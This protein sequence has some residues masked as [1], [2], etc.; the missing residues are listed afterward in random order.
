MFSC[1]FYQ[2]FQ[3]PVFAK[4]LW[5]TASAKYPFLFVT[6]TSATKN[7]SFDLGYFKYFLD[8]HCEQLFVEVLERQSAV[9]KLIYW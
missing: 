6:P 9:T 4:H 3:N 5:M 2:M 7:V 8:K 1:V